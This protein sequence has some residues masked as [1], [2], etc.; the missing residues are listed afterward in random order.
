MVIATQK[1]EGEKKQAYKTT[2]KKEHIKH[3][4]ILEVAANNDTK[5]QNTDFMARV[6]FAS[7]AANG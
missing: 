1:K 2:L 6:Q 4:H 5:P 7:V 3:K